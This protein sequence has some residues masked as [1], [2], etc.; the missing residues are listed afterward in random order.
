MRCVV[1]S[2]QVNPGIEI[3]IKPLTPKGK[4]NKYIEDIQMFGANMTFI[5]SGE[6]K[7][8]YIS[9]VNFLFIIYNTFDRRDANLV[10]ARGS[11]T[12]SFVSWR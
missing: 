11:L 8:M 7:K 6:V 5:S 2:K 12:R 1:T 3:H 9:L 10:F 4:I